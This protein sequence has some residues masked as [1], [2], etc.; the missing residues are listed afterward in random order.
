MPAME[1]ILKTIPLKL[2]NGVAEIQDTL[3]ESR[4]R[5]TEQGELRY[6]KMLSLVE[7]GGSAQK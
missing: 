1:K 7:S 2:Q 3:T 6:S 5:Q 4:K